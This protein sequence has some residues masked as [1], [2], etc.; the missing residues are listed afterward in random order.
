MYRPEK[1]QEYIAT[2]EGESDNEDEEEDEMDNIE[3]QMALDPSEA[4]TEPISEKVS[5]RMISI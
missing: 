4:V 5:T 1:L 3:T 2:M